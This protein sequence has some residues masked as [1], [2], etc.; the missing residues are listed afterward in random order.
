MD[1]K[2]LT[3]LT[4]GTHSVIHRSFGGILR[5]FIVGV[6]VYTIVPDRV[7][8]MSD[9]KLIDTQPRWLLIRVLFMLN[10]LYSPFCCN[11][12]LC[13]SWSVLSD[14]VS[15]FLHSR[16]STFPPRLF[17]PLR[18]RTS[19]CLRRIKTKFSPTTETSQ[20]SSWLFRK[21]PVSLNPF[22]PNLFH[23]KDKN[24]KSLRINTVVWTFRIIFVGIIV[25]I[26]TIIDN[27][28]FLN[29]E[30][31][32]MCQ[33]RNIQYQWLKSVGMFIHDNN[34]Y[35]KMSNFFFFCF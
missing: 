33:T 8:S 6:N 31:F 28:Q 1:F 10:K 2:G 11:S 3:N 24:F 15:S 29:E 17:L 9:R 13:D 18:H 32:M 19:L 20:D 12:E 16:F 23:F 14:L 5:F 35:Y 27:G 21:R 26:I 34:V 25:I 7:D 22:P 4:N 30:K